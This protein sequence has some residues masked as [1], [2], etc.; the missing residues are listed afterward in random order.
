MST[1]TTPTSTAGKNYSLDTGLLQEIE[2]LSNA[3]DVH[4]CAN[5]VSC[6]RSAVSEYIETEEDDFRLIAEEAHRAL[7]VAVIRLRYLRASMPLCRFGG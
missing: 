2:T 3:A 7:R 5:L 1:S 6:Y 4:K